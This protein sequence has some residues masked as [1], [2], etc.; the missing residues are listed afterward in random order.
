MLGLGIGEL[1]II[2]GIVVLLFGAKKV[3]QLM[4]GFGKGIRDLRK[5][6]QEEPID[7]KPKLPERTEDDK[8]EDRK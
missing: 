1:G 5:G 6:F 8:H 2:A 4:E 3:P 7:D